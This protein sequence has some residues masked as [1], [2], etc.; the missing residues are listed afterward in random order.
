MIL[1]FRPPELKPQPIYSTEGNSMQQLAEPSS[2]QPPPAGEQQQSGEGGSGQ[3]LHSRARSLSTSFLLDTN[4]S[5]D[6]PP[7]DDLIASE[8]VSPNQSC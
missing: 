7:P 4:F 3:Q 1:L 5:L 8:H 2:I 6:I